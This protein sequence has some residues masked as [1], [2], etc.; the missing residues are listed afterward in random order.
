MKTKIKTNS[1]EVQG[2]GDYEAAKHYGDSVKDFV[3]SGKVEKASKTA[4]PISTE[5]E[6]AMDKAEKIGRSKSKGEDPS[7]PMS[8]K[9]KA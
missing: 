1:A 3:S 9:R 6:I 5:E 8:P 2:E 4:K 7:S